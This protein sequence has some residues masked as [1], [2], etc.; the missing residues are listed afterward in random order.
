MMC[1]RDAGKELAE[2]RRDG[3]RSEI[4]FAAAMLVVQLLDAPRCPA[5]L[6]KAL[7]AL[8]LGSSDVA[9]KM[10]NPGTSNNVL[11]HECPAGSK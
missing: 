8:A 7:H 4:D 1:D 11:N 3:V 6:D 5:P 2:R 10:P 9:W